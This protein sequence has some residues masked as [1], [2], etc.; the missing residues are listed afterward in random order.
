MEHA[1][2]NRNN[3]KSIRAKADSKY[4][5]YKAK[6]R[7]RKLASRMKLL[8]PLELEKKRIQNRERARLYRLKKKTV[9]TGSPVP[10][11][12][13]NGIEFAY[14]SPQA[15]GK[16][17]HK[18]TSHLPHKPRKKWQYYGSLPNLVECH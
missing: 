10:T 2:K 11:Y 1:E 3:R 4:A 17:V 8:S 9:A 18:I 7:E 15:L 14:K 5:A 16:A 6:D 13:I 12:D